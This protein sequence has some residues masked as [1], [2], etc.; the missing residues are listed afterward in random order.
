MADFA[1]A[2][3]GDNQYDIKSWL[4][5]RWGKV[6]ATT[7]GVTR[8]GLPD[9]PTGPNI[10]GYNLGSYSMD[11]NAVRLDKQ[12]QNSS[13]LNHELGHAA[14]HNEM[15]DFDRQGWINLHNTYV[16]VH[17]KLSKMNAPA[18]Q[19]ARSI[20]WSISRYK[21]NPAH[22]FADAFSDYTIAPQHMR[23]NYPDIYH[24]FL[25]KTG[26]TEYK[27]TGYK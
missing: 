21:D 27:F 25:N 8:P 9:Q 3:T 19:L 20:P 4:P 18:D 1:K 15:D 17:D 10:F 12:G 24:F 2:I 26:G 14:W 7:I 22:S 11:D 5:P 23:Q 13:V 6:A 16:G